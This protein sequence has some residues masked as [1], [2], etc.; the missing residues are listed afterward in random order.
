M[1]A[2][3]GLQSPARGGAYQEPIRKPERCVP[4]PFSDSSVQ[5][6]MGPGQEQRARAAPRAVPRCRK[7]QVEKE[8]DVKQEND[9][10][11][12]VVLRKEG[13]LTP[14]SPVYFHPPPPESYKPTEQ[15]LRKLERGQSSL[16]PSTLHSYKFKKPLINQ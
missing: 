10:G 9:R 13:Y 12:E 7:Q 5:Q 3:G 8:D 6:W 16:S 15:E 14:S 4:S 2:V 11:E 1:S